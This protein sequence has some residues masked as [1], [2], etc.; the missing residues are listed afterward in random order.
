MEVNE[1][2]GAG[3]DE[4]GEEANLGDLPTSQ[5]T[6]M[7][8]G[9]RMILLMKIVVIAATAVAVVGKMMRS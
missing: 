2:D 6:S 8:E 9:K 3:E 1:A 4:E 5:N 7:I